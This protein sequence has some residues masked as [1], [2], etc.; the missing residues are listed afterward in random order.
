MYSNEWPGN[1]P[2]RCLR[3][4]GAAGRPAAQTGTLASVAQEGTGLGAGAP[5][6]RTAAGR[7][8]DGV[9]PSPGKQCPTGLKLKACL[10]S[11]QRL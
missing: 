11:Q 8:R 6:G 9:A 2:V 10:V 1:P 7:S 5:S 3:T 4:P